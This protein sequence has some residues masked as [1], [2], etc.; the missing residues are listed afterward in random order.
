MYLQE[1]IEQKKSEFFK[2]NDTES[3]TRCEKL[4]KTLSSDLDNSMKQGAYVTLGGHQV[5][6]EEMERIEEKYKNE[7][8]KGTKVG[9]RVNG[10]PQGHTHRGHDV[11]R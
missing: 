1:I 4:I 9:V 7:P 6:K 3:R 10:L 11:T 5:F 8:R 2:R